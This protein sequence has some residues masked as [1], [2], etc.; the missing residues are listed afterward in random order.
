MVISHF[1]FRLYA[2]TSRTYVAMLFLLGA[3][4]AANA[5]ASTL[6]IWPVY[7]LIESDQ[8]STALWVEN[9]G[10]Q[11]V[12]IQLRVF[13]WEQ[14]DNQ[15]LTLEQNNIVGSPPMVEIDPGERQL[16]RLVAQHT[17]PANTEQAWRVLLDEIPTQTSPNSGSAMRAAINVQMRYSLPLFSYG[18]GLSSEA[19][20]TTAAT[21]LRW[22]V[23]VIEGQPHLV[24]TN[25]GPTHARLSDVQSVRHEQA[26]HIQEGLLGYVLAHSERHWPLATTPSFSSLQARVNGGELTSLEKA[27]DHP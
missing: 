11:S 18:K 17:T 24:I 2:R 12:F 3:C 27:N 23:K 19:A 21:Q 5:S 20:K 7:P 9:R 10:N 25:L 6:L 15:D 16:I 26:Q 1:F 13:A 14:R 22:Q 4:V 8:N